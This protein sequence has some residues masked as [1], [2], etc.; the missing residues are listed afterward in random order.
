MLPPISWA[1]KR[2]KPARQ[3]QAPLGKPASLAPKLQVSTRTEINGR[4]VGS[5]YEANVADALDKL[6][7]PYYY[8]Y[9][10][11][12]GRRRRG[13]LVLDFLILTRPLRT[14]LY[15]NGGYWHSLRTEADRL[16]QAN[17][18]TYFSYPVRN[19]LVMWDPECIS[20]DVAYAWL[21]PRI[22]RG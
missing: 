7:W 11:N 1:P 10:V 2:S 9:S 15:V 22:G 14:P 21:L 18:S 6:G 12:N 17:M 19:S 3:V 20:I 8:Q 5:S 13:G 16:Q 4:P